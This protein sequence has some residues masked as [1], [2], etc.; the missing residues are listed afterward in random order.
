MTSVTRNRWAQAAT[1]SMPPITGA[2]AVR[3]P[4]RVGSSSSRPDTKYPPR[5][6][7]INWAAIANPCGEPSMT[8]ALR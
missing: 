7:D 4:C 2:T 3:E 1:W 6:A 5:F 8:R